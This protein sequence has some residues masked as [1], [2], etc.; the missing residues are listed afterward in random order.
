MTPPPAETA[1]PAPQRASLWEDIVEVYFAPKD[2]FARRVD[3]RYGAAVVVLTVLTV[4]LAFG[5]QQTLGPAFDAEFQRGMRQAAAGGGPQPTPEQLATMRT[6][7][8][9]AIIGSSLVFTPVMAFLTGGIVWLLARVMGSAIAFGIAMAI[10]TWSLYPGILRGVAMILEG[11]LMAPES[12]AA[13][14]FG[15]ARFF[16][17]DTTSPALMAMLGRVEIFAL[18]GALLIAIGLRV[19]G[20]VPAGKAYAIAAIVWAVA[21]I[22]QLVGALAQGG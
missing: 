5:M 3:G 20:R 6:F 7:S 19:A 9:Y 12:L 13:A 17:P 8:G 2:L 21:V 1:T 14:S 10:A 11:I 15:L 22:P 16:D 4:F 18:W